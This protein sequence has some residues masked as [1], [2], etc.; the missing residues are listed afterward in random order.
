MPR[1]EGGGEGG[2]DGGRDGG[3]GAAAGC[4]VVLGSFVELLRP[5]LGA[6]SVG[7][8]ERG[9]GLTA[10]PETRPGLGAGAGGAVAFTGMSR[11]AGSP[12]P[13]LSDSRSAM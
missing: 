6:R 13:V 1:A 9:L 12:L 7:D 10:T 5:G 11:P 3:G 2:D 8:A 4:P